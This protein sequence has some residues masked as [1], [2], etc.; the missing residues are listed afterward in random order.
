MW[1][2]KK[3]CYPVPIPKQVLLEPMPLTF[4]VEDAIS[5]SSGFPFVKLLVMDSAQAFALLISF[6]SGDLF[7][8]LTNV[9]AQCS[10]GSFLF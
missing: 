2:L 3:C 10:Q 8:I 4:L 9:M 6:Y 7:L 1:R 5:G